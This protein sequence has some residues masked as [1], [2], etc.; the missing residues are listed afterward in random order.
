MFRIVFIHLLVCF[1]IFFSSC[2]IAN[3]ISPPTSL[4]NKV[5]SRID[6]ILVNE[7]ILVYDYSN[8]PNFEFYSEGDN[9]YKYY[10]VSDNSAGG[11]GPYYSHS[12]KQFRISRLDSLVLVYYKNG[13]LFN[14]FNYFSNIHYV[15]SINMADNSFSRKLSNNPFEP[16]SDSV[17]FVQFKDNDSTN[18]SIILDGLRFVQVFKENLGLVYYRSRIG[19]WM[20]VDYDECVLTSVNDSEFAGDSLIARLKVVTNRFED[21]INSATA[22][23][24]ILENSSFDSISWE[25]TETGNDYLFTNDTIATV[26]WELHDKIVLKKDSSLLAFKN[27]DYYQNDY[28]YPYSYDSLVVIGDSIYFVVKPYFYSNLL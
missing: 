9:N 11:L 15:R 12:E 16:L 7:N 3:V 4:E 17:Y 14:S 5:N 24:L 1:C 26:N 22:L 20:D 28:L 27:T 19:N 25:R 6:S 2:N 10:C 18:L 23:E 21:S 13:D 8:P